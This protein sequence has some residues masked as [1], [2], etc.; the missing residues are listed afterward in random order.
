MQISVR[1]K[2]NLRVEK[3]LSVTSDSTSSPSTVSAVNYRS[4]AFAVDNAFLFSLLVNQRLKFNL[5]FLM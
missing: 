3:Q 5:L 4:M 2:K 1:L